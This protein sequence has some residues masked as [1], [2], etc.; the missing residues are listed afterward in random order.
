MNS[1]TS[2]GLVVQDSIPVGT[3]W[4]HGGGPIPAG[5]LLCDGAAYSRAQYSRLFAQIGVLHGAGNG[6]TTF[7]VPNVT[8]K[9]IIGNGIVGAAAGDTHTHGVGTYATSAHSAHSSNA[10]IDNHGHSGHGTHSNHG[11]SDNGDP[12]LWGSSENLTGLFTGPT[13]PGNHGHAGVTTGGG[14]TAGVNAPL[15]HSH[16]AGHSHGVGGYQVH[17]HASHDDHGHDNNGSIGDHGHT[18]HGAHGD[19]AAHTL[20]GSSAAMS[21]SGIRLNFIIKT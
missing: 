10:A 6:T 13:E 2:S 11:H 15:A 16:T 3:I 5:W 18:G 9:I 12:Y 17:G 19:H 4:M 21:A 8:D 1:G 7:N 14:T 20:S